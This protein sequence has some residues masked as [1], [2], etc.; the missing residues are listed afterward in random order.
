MKAYT[1]PLGLVGA[2]LM[3][4]G[5]T[6]YLLNSESDSAGLFNMALR[7]LMVSAAGL[8]NPALFRQYGRWL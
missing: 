3:V 1:T 7:A 2:A 5:G 4:A 8:L 6:A